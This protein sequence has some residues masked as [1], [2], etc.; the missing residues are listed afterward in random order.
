MGGWRH[1]SKSP[2]D[3]GTKKQRLRKLQDEADFVWQ[4]VSIL[5]D[6]EVDGI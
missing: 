1:E 4:L 3:L 5:K 2:V 6:S